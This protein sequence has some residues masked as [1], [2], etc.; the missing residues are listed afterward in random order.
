MPARR[1]RRLIAKQTPY[2]DQATRGPTQS[3][4]PVLRLLL[5]RHSTPLPQELPV[6]S[7]PIPSAPIPLLQ[8]TIPLPATP[9][10]VTPSTALTPVLLDPETLTSASRTSSQ[11]ILPSISSSSTLPPHFHGHGMFHMAQNF[12][13]S[14][15]HFIDF[16]PTGFGLERLLK[17]SMPDAFYNSSAR[18]PPPKCHFGTRKDYIDLVT[19]WA[20]G[21][22]DRKEPILWMRGPFGVGKSAIAQSCAEALAPM[23]KLAA[24][25]FFSRSNPDRDDPRRVFMSIVYQIATKCPS[26]R[27]I[28]ARRMA[29]DP[30][31][32][33]MS[34]STQ[35]ETMLIDPLREVDAIG[36]SLGG[37]VVVIDGL[38]ECRGT[39][40]QCEIV[41]IIAASVDKCTTPFRWFITSR[42]EDPI[43]RAMT[44]AA[45]SPTCS[46][47]ELPVSREIDHEILL[48]LTDEFRKIREDHGLPDSWPSEEALALLVEHGA[49]LWIYV[50]TMVRFIKDENSYGPEDQ[51]RIV[52]EFAKDVSSK[53]VENP[54][55]EM[56][57]FYTL[58]MQRVPSKLLT[59]V[60]K[61]LLVSSIA[62]QDPESIADILCLSVEKLRRACAPIR[63]VMELEG[64]DL[65]SMSITFY[66]ASFLDFMKDPQRSKELC[67]YGDFLIGQRQELL[68]QLHEVCSQSTGAVLPDPCGISCSDEPPCYLQIPGTLYFPHVLFSQKVYH[69]SI[70]TSWFWN[71]FG[72]FVVH[73]SIH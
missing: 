63:S 11:A 47:I 21:E 33:A 27:E 22:S 56:D 23:N 44:S 26:F 45:V 55:A 41:R 54:L 15:S 51:L 25:L 66:H 13:I 14:N 3:E 4:D 32:A 59:T 40:E 36:S 52:V 20:L 42:P 8:P 68:E 12:T 18:Y 70:T 71:G 72:N 9:L 34:L 30:A 39:A 49:G 67:I 73:P 60:R 58:I 43:I 19:K 46:R 61:I 37:R 48:F 16:S 1:S 38:D 53:F 5:A 57:F 64:T 24:T 31:L 50:A 10:S 28:I 29:E 17:H 7:A 2:P 65:T 6:S 62:G 69:M 35:F